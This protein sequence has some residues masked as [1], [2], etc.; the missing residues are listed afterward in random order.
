MAAANIFNLEAEEAHSALR[1]A[2]VTQQVLDVGV[3]DFEHRSPT[4]SSDCFMEENLR[5]QVTLRPQSDDDC[6]YNDDARKN[7]EPSIDY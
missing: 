3:A 7:A 1:S 6:E 5:A 4:N 2:S